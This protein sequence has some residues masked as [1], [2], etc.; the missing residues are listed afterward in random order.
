[1]KLTEHF[2][3]EEFLFS[4]T[5]ARRG[6]DNTPPADVRENLRRNAEQMEIVRSALGGVPIRITSGYRSLALNRAIGSKDTSAHVKGL[7]CDFVAPEFGTPAEICRALVAKYVVFEKLIYEHTWVH[8]AW[9]A[10][11][12]IAHGQVFTLMPGGSYALGI[13]ERSAA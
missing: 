7:A 12:A 3:L 1:M 9:P 11:G 10:V 6:I 4:S 5:A 8:I 13:H 2:T